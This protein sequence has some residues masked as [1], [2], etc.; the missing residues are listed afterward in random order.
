MSSESDARLLPWLVALA[1]V[2]VMAK[3]GGGRY[4]LYVDLM[5]YLNVALL[6]FWAVA[7]LQ[8]ARRKRRENPP[9]DL[10]K[11]SERDEEGG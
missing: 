4:P 1:A 8:E 6:A 10:L 9:V 2:V 3:V 7:H 11:R 5:V